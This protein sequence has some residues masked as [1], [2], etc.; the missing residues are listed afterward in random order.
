M[1]SISCYRANRLKF[2]ITQ[3]SQ[4]LSP[5]MTDKDEQVRYWKE[6]AKVHQERLHDLETEFD[7]FRESSSTLER[8][9][10]KDLDVAEK[11]IKEMRVKNNRLIFDLEESRVRR[12][13]SFFFSNLFIC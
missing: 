12:K 9:L 10:E 8:E 1:L 11:T 13:I 7:E 5:R 3:L 4:D 2:Q 6:Q